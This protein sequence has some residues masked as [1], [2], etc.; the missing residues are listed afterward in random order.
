M[1]DAPKKLTI[2]TLLAMLLVTMTGSAV[3][4]INDSA[5]ARIEYYLTHDKSQSSVPIP[6]TYYVG[7]TPAFSDGAIDTQYV[8]LA[9]SQIYRADFNTSAGTNATFIGRG[10]NS[11]S[12]EVIDQY[13]IS[14][15]EQATYRVG[16]NMSSNVTLFTPL[17][18][19][20]FDGSIN[21]T[22]A[23]S[24]SADEIECVTTYAI[25]ETAYTDAGNPGTNYG[26]ATRM[27]VRNDAWYVYNAW[28]WT[29]PDPN[30]YYMIS[31]AVAHLYNSYSS[32]RPLKLYSS[33][34][35]D[36]STI[37]QASEPT[38]S[39]MYAFPAPSSNTWSTFYLNSSA[40]YSIQEEDF[41]TAL[42]WHTDFVT[43][44]DAGWPSAH[45]YATYNYNKTGAEAGRLILQTDTLETL[46]TYKSM[47]MN[48]QANDR[49]R[50]G[51]NTTG[52]HACNLSLN[53]ILTYEIVPEGNTITAFQQKNV[54]IY[55]ALTLNTLTLNAMLGAD[56][57]ISIDY[58]V[59]ER[60]YAPAVRIDDLS[61]NHGGSITTED[62]DFTPINVT[63]TSYNQFVF[64]YTAVSNFTTW[65]GTT[66]CYVIAQNYT[67]AVNLTYFAADLLLTFNLTLS[68]STT[69]ST[70]PSEANLQANGEIVADLS[71]DSGFV[72]FENFQTSIV[73]TADM[74]IYAT[75][76][77]TSYLTTTRT[78]TTVTSTYL[79]DTF[80]LTTEDLTLYYIKTEGIEGILHLYVNGEDLG[81]VTETYCSIDI[82]SSA[83]TKVELILYEYIHIPLIP[84]YNSL[85]SGTY[86]YYCTGRF[87]ALAYNDISRFSDL[88]ITLSGFDVEQANLTFS[89]LK[90]SPNYTTDP[91]N[92]T[93]SQWREPAP[94]AAPT[95]ISNDTFS[96]FEHSNV[97]A[98]F[99]SYANETEYGQPVYNETIEKPGVLV[100]S[101][102]NGS[103]CSL[104]NGTVISGTSAELENSDDSYYEIDSFR[105]EE[106]ARHA[107]G[108][109]D[110]VICVDE[111]GAYAP[112]IGTYDG[113]DKV[114]RILDNGGTGSYYVFWSWYVHQTNA[115]R[116]D[117]GMEIEF[118]VYMNSFVGA[119]SFFPQEIYFYADGGA[120]TPLYIG[121]GAVGVSADYSLNLQN[122]AAVT[123]T[124]FDFTASTW[125]TCRIVINTNGA[126]AGRG[127]YDFYVDGVL[128]ADDYDFG[129][130]GEIGP[131]R[132]LYGRTFIA[133]QGLVEINRFYTSSAEWN[134]TFYLQHDLT[135][136]DVSTVTLW[137]EAACN[138]S[139][140][141][142]VTVYDPATASFAL[143][144][145]ETLGAEQY[146]S[147]DVT[148]YVHDDRNVT[149]RLSRKGVPVNVELDAI[150][151]A[152]N[153]TEY[154]NESPHIGFTTFSPRF[155][156]SDNKTIGVNVTGTDVGDIKVWNNISTLNN[157]IGTGEGIFY[158]NISE[159][160]GDSPLNFTLTIYATCALGLVT[161]YTI[162]NMSIFR[163][164]ILPFCGIYF[165]KNETFTGETNT[166][167]ITVTETGYSIA[168][169]YLWNNQTGNATL[170]TGAGEF[171]YYYGSTTVLTYNISIR[172]EDSVGQWLQYNYSSLAVIYNET[173]PS[174][175]VG[176]L[177]QTYI[178][179][180]NTFHTNA[181]GP[182]SE[183]KLW[184]NVSCVNTTLGTGAGQ[185]DHALIFNSAINYTIRVY[186]TDT[187]NFV[188]SF[189]VRDII[190]QKFNLTVDFLDLYTRY[191]QNDTVNLTTSLEATSITWKS[192]DWVEQTSLNDNVTFY[193][194]TSVQVGYWNATLIFNS[195][196]F[197]NLTRVV[198][199]EILPILR[200]VN[201]TDVNLSVNWIAVVD[202]FISLN[203]TNTIFISS[204]DNCSFDLVIAITANNTGG[205]F[206]YSGDALSF[207]WQFNQ[208]ATFTAYTPNQFFLSP[209]PTNFTQY[210]Y[211]S[212]ASSNYTVAGERLNIDQ[213]N[214]T[215]THGASLSVTLR[216]PT[217][218]ITRSQ[219]T[220]APSTTDASVV[221]QARGYTNRTYKYYYWDTEYDL[222]SLSV[223][224]DRTGAATSSF[225]QVESKHYF[226][227]EAL[228]ND[229]FTVLE[230]IRPNWQTAV[231][232]IENNGTYTEITL[233][234]SAALNI[235]NVQTTIDLGTTLNENWTTP[236]A[237]VTFTQINASFQ[238][239]VAGLNFTNTTQ[240]ITIY[241]ASQVPRAEVS[242]IL[243]A[244]GRIAV[245]TV[246]EFNGILRY[247][248]YSE[249]YL[250]PTRSYW[251]TYSV[252]YGLS[253]YSCQR[254]SDDWAYVETGGM[255]PSVRFSYL[256]FKAA[257]FRSV[258]FNQTGSQITVYIDSRFN[259]TN[260]FF[261]YLWAEDR[262]HSLSTGNA[263]V[264]DLTDAGY[265][266]ENGTA[267]AEGYLF[268]WYDVAEGEQWIVI[269][270][271]Y[272]SAGEYFSSGIILVVVSSLFVAAYYLQRKYDLWDRLKA[273]VPKRIVEKFQKDPE[274]LVV[275][276]KTS[277][278][279][280]MFRKNKHRK[281]E[282]TK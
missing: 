68:Y 15:G 149:V 190:V 211:N 233:T 261:A 33:G 127:N 138:T 125:Q 185:Y 234:Y 135:P 189:E 187:Y 255:D 153:S 168:G 120:S 244:R 221:F 215:F 12:T 148:S 237:G 9:L 186:I 95:T 41:N 7:A 2:C 94:V 163:A 54:T 128:R 214:Q 217:N 111:G 101:D 174:A 276:A 90:Y 81:A 77:C 272:M 16:G 53:G 253:N 76:N 137:Y 114:L 93:S 8:D 263:S 228:V 197:L 11:T 29:P 143:V 183:V 258:D 98:S 42:A 271:R 220:S 22:E 241:G 61:I 3:R 204:L 97:S 199:F 240:T 105:C 112:A 39:L 268:F 210:Y 35:F 278:G 58:I 142:N 1:R 231:S 70:V 238:L 113:R 173:R 260:V 184:D 38:V 84:F 249:P 196:E 254:V 134:A 213:A 104:T 21:D 107:D 115:I 208:S 236:S 177:S 45:P 108:G 116:F 170:G 222:A 139:A 182:I 194:N 43:E 18:T 144:T 223:T 82:V 282:K 151:L 13:M 131:L 32:S 50:I 178:G 226:T 48:L 65:D 250:I 141:M 31:D 203:H 218:Q 79:R 103:Y 242:Q 26:G 106:I 75:Y 36:E 20:D 59:I 167:H 69:I 129:T 47:T 55:D 161:N 155:T 169:V 229:T 257:P 30:D 230:S 266:D 224:H 239:T 19:I 252:E 23:F 122:G 235:S 192:P 126:G 200:S 171:L 88:G 152:I 243:N 280:L 140:T 162:A 251:E 28:L 180:A 67:I 46:S 56:E 85:G 265:V 83:I 63:E 49:I 51:F 150:S 64:N 110:G 256:Y 25:S 118:D 225:E 191:Y 14:A 40:A 52:T 86:S 262:V 74:D 156:T 160:L 205:G 264:D 159:H 87:N 57:Y 172:I 275:V 166:F 89:D 132:S 109:P 6:G 123:D 62:V 175:L 209:I 133:Q 259:L 274:E 269:N 216:R 201:S 34:A 188:Q 164:G 227:Q 27:Y 176:Y 117:A 91:T 10:W 219:V 24:M 99:A 121:F 245:D 202:N 165:Y 232:W 267:V 72:S 60:P 17:T 248:R 154:P 136:A 207:S 124:G 130:A 281:K 119:A 92:Y 273:K 181:S 279:E 4:G 158:Y 78:P 73:Y 247:P 206:S 71:R 44:D 157:T 198:S 147:L 5:D 145:S 80:I 102:V 277:E 96:Q 246:L 212:I 270:V 37:T 146:F 193:T 179:Q 100:S 66:D 195:T